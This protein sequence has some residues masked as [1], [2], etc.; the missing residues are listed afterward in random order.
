MAE[1]ALSHAGL[2]AQIDATELIH[3]KAAF[4]WLGQLSFAVKVGHTVIYLDPY[5]AD[6]AARQTPPLL[7]PEEVTNASLC[8][9]SHDHGDHID[10]EAVGGI[11]AASPDCKFVVPS[12]H[13]ERV[14]ELGCPPDS[15]V[16]LRP[17]ETAVVAGVKITGVK[18]KH[19]SFDETD[20]GFPH[21]GYILEANGV[22]FYHAGD[23]LVYEGLVTTLAQYPLDAIF[24][25][26]NGRDARRYRS[27]C[28]GN[29]TYQE[30]VDLAG[31]VRP[32]LVVPA[33]Y[34]MFA[35]NSADPNEFADYL[36][37]KFPDLPCWIGPAGDK[38][39]FGGPWS[40]NDRPA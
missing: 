32:H 25:P 15:V 20:L 1:V 26:I 36:D 19:E 12:P 11:A 2:I 27:G 35:S 30:A 38:V 39:I 21:L 8:T 22:C 17:D 7:R 40:E 14:I 23:T 37:A 9:G 33:H 13:V 31:D 24:V 4:W 6:D 5:L 28:I 34:D 18:A 10:P 29:M 16:G 3:G